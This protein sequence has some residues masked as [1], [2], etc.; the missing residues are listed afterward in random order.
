VGINFNCD[1]CNEPVDPKKR[2]S[3]GL[4][5]ISDMCDYCEDIITKTV[6]LMKISPWDKK[7]VSIHS[8]MMEAIRRSKE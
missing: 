5:N 7:V 4:R 1:I 8:Q 6:E 3:I 2:R